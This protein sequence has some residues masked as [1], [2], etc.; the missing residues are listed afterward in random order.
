MLV[1]WVLVAEMYHGE[2]VVRLR[3]ELEKGQRNSAL[4]SGS[5]PYSEDFKALS[6]TVSHLTSEETCLTTHSNRPEER[7][8]ERVKKECKRGKKHLSSFPALQSHLHWCTAIR[9]SASPNLTTT[10]SSTSPHYSTP[11]TES[12]ELEHFLAWRDSD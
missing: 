10:T 4:V 2:N 9:L 11:I 7:E 8:R 6:R 3:G 12:T 5:W 1:E